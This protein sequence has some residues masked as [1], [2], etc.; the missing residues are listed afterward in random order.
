MPVAT[1]G[2]LTMYE[3]LIPI[4]LSQVNTATP[5]PTTQKL[6]IVNFFL[7]LLFPQ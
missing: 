1:A 3:G 6:K 5:S 7:M 4:K 2:A